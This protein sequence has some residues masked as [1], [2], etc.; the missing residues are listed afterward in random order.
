ML[1]QKI[2]KYLKTSKRYLFTRIIIM[3]KEYIYRDQNLLFTDRKY[4]WDILRRNRPVTKFKV[5]DRFSGIFPACPA[6]YLARP[7]SEN[8]TINRFDLNFGFIAGDR[9]SRQHYVDVGVLRVIP[10]ILQDLEAFRRSVFARCFPTNILISAS[11]LFLICAWLNTSRSPNKAEMSRDVDRR[12]LSDLN[13]ISTRLIIMVLCDV[14]QLSHLIFKSTF[15][16]KSDKCNWNFHL[17]K[18]YFIL[19]SNTTKISTFN[20]ANVIEKLQNF[21]KM[22]NK[23]FKN[24]INCFQKRTNTKKINILSNIYSNTCV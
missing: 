14:F 8:V 18:F 15:S 16:L 5:T 6:T 2:S 12:K 19:I 23:I 1:S 3:L 20:D 11:R 7:S 24:V 17:T 9:L 13:V 10:I 21:Y 22:S 4:W